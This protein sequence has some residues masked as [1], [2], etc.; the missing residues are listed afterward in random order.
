MSNNRLWKRR[1]Q[2]K[3]N[4]HNRRHGRK[5]KG[6]SNKTMHERA[7]SLFRSFGL[8]RRLGYQIDPSNLAGTHIQVLV[9]YWTAVRAWPTCVRATVWTCSNGHTA[10]PTFSSMSFLRVYA[11]AWIGKPG[12]VRPLAHYVD[13]RAASSA[14]IAPRKTEAGKATLSSSSASSTRLP[15]SARRRPAGAAVRV[16]A[17]AQGSGDVHAAYRRRWPRQ[18]SRFAAPL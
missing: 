15:R 13:D 11:T 7:S 1:L 4:E 18:R 9:D 8:L 2:D 5:A 16:R 3:I 10:Q 17:T 14:P 12:M 6:V